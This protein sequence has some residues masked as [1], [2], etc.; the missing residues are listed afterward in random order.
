M[1]SIHLQL[2]SANS[3]KRDSDV[4]FVFELFRLSILKVQA[5]QVAFF[6]SCLFIAFYHK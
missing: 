5:A 2:F 3:S 4:D 1:E 6:I